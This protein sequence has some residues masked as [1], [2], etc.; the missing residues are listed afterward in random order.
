MPAGR[1]RGFCLS[2]LPQ[3]KTSLRL[4]LPLAHQAVGVLVRL[5]LKK[6]AYWRVLNLSQDGGSNPGPAAYE[7][8]ALPAELSWH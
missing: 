8:A 6:P 5:R 4:S 3:T 2:A 7:A 1:A